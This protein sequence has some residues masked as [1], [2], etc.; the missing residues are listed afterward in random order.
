MI[1]R[2]RAKRTSVSRR[3]F[4]FVAAAGSGA[5]LGGS[6]LATPA[7]AQNKRPQRAVSYKASPNGRQSC[8]TCANFQAPSSCKLVDGDISP[9]GWCLLYAAK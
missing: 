9:S 2:K 3:D 5:V 6:L 8:S 4:L 1:D 7:F